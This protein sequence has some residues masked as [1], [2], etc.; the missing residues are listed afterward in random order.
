MKL[1]MKDRNMLKNFS[2]FALLLCLALT[3]GVGPNA[4]AKGGAA[5]LE[6]GAEQLTQLKAALTLLNEG[7]AS[8]A[9]R[10]LQG[11]NNPA[12][13]G[14]ARA[15]NVARLK[16][17]TFNTL[18]PEQMEQAVQFARSNGVA[19]ALGR[20]E[21]AVSA[22]E[23][24]SSFSLVAALGMT[25]ED[26]PPVPC[27]GKSCAP[28]ARF[29]SSRVG[30]GSADARFQAVFN[31][32]FRLSGGDGAK[33]GVNQTTLQQVVSKMNNLSKQPNGDDMMG[34][35]AAVWQAASKTHLHCAVSQQEACR[36][37]GLNV[38]MGLIAS[39]VLDEGGPPAVRF[40]TEGLFP[41]F[42]EDRKKG[43]VYDHAA[44]LSGAQNVLATPQSQWEP[45]IRSC[46]YGKYVN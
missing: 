34:R 33:L 25:V 11:M 38:A 40:A 41:S 8:Q 39:P 26:R 22:T 37:M 9:V 28:T 32:V 19:A 12:A 45:T 36:T 6:A 44:L 16:G 17:V 1:Y 23:K 35:I 29:T 7:K 18:S 31:E 30:E 42:P 2:C 3:I 27:T 15:L 21:S 43:A 4:F 5:A 20:L 10:F 13:A 24:N 46:F 14:L